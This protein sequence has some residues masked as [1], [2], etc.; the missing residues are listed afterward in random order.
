MIFKGISREFSL[1]NE[2][3]YNTIGAFWDEMAGIYGLERLRGLGYL[4]SGGKIF[5]AIGLKDGDIRGYDLCIELPD[6]NW[7]EVDGRTDRLQE[8]YEEIYKSGALKYEIETFDDDGK[9]HIKY[10]R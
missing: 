2:E 10:Y 9:C 8:I 7:C 6:E 5:Y 1:F 3:Q 4:W